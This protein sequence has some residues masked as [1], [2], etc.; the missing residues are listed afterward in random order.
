[1]RNWKG[2]YIFV[3]CICVC[4]CACVFVSSFVC[5][6]IVLLL[7]EGLQHHLGIADVTAGMLCLTSTIIYFFFLQGG[8]QDESDMSLAET[9]VRVY[10]Y[11]KPCELDA[12]L[13]NA[14][15]KIGIPLDVGLPPARVCR[16]HSCSR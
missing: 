10:W 7:Q 3:W 8:S 9:F 16:R 2:V 1:M 6:A 5:P 13:I 4:V 12:D 14:Q 11:Y 15:L